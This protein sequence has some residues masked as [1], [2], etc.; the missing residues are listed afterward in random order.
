VD[1]AQVGHFGA[2]RAHHRFE[3]LVN[4][5]QRRIVGVGGNPG[6]DDGNDQAPEID[7]QQQ[8]EQPQ[9]C[10]HQKVSPGDVGAHAGDQQNQRHGDN[11]DAVGQQQ[12]GNVQTAEARNNPAQRRQQRAGEFDDHLRNGVVKISAYQ[13]QQKAQQHNQ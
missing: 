3:N 10:P 5:N 9:R 7:L 12:R 1:A 8:P 13:L 11:L 2:D 4:Q 6:G